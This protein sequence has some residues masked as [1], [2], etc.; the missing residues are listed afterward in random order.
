M[1]LVTA[2]CGSRKSSLSL[3]RIY[4]LVKPNDPLGVEITQKV[5]KLWKGGGVGYQMMSALKKISG[6]NMVPLGHRLVVRKM[7]HQNGA[8]FSKW[9]PKGTIL[10]PFFL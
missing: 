8:F 9:C 4:M 7:G 5:A 10:V 6:T 2:D 3:A 1:I